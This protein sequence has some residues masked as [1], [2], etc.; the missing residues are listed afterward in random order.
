MIDPVDDVTQPLP[1]ATEC[2]I[3]LQFSSPE[4]TYTVI[5]MQDLFKQWV[6]LQAW[7]GKQN[8]GGGS[9]PRPFDN[10]EAGLSAL[11]AIARKHEQRGYLPVN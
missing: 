5:L 9:K 4:R 8:T 2:P 10:L 7:A 1:V 6:I 3:R 11:A